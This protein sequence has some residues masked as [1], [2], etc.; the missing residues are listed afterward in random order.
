MTTGMGAE[1]QQGDGDKQIDGEA[2]IDL[3]ALA[4]R[5]VLRFLGGL[6]GGVRRGWGRRRPPWIRSR[7]PIGRGGRVCH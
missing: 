4:D 7:D 1:C 2:E 5:G 3:V 6:G